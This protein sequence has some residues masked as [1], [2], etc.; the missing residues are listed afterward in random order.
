MSTHYQVDKYNFLYSRY[1]YSGEFTPQNLVFNAN[2]QEFSQRV[3][4]ICNLQT[5]GKL[6]PQESY[7]QIEKLWE[8]V[9]QSYEALEIETD[10]NS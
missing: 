10:T 4:Y 2:L 7:N 5:R 9:K 8:Q 1:R 6:S 3:G